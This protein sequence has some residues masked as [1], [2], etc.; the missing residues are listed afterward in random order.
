MKKIF[1]LILAGILS[2]MVL[3]GCGSDPLEDELKNFINVEMAEPNANYVAITTEAAK[4]GELESNEA[5]LSS[6]NDVLIPKCD[7][8][9]DILSKVQPEAEELKELKDKY[10]KVFELYKEGFG[11]ML[12]VIDTGDEAKAS[13]VQAKIEEGISTLN[14]YNAGLEALAAEKGLKIEY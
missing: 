10:I 9:L 5:V 2:V 1:S 11:L 4:W 13:E 6:I 8:T 3:T 12:E 7:E 14:E